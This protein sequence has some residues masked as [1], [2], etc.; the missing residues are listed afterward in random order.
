MYQKMVLHTWCMLENFPETQQ[1]RWGKGLSQ[2][3][4]IPLAKAQYLSE[5]H[6]S[7]PASKSGC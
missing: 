5:Q 6:L 1:Q 3:G 4:V 7:K 2:A